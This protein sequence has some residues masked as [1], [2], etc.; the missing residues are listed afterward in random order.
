[1]VAC[2]SSLRATTILQL[3]TKIYLYF[4]VLLDYFQ[5]LTKFSEYDKNNDLILWNNRRITIE[6]NSVLWKQWFDQGVTFISDLMNSNGKFLTFE[7]FQNKF[8]IK[9]NYL[10]YFQLIAAIPPDLK[11]KA[12][13]STVPDLLGATSEYCQIEDRTIVFLKIITVCSSR[14][15]L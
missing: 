5:E 10:H 2:P 6:R 1:M 15:L 14:N 13:G 12:F 3:L 9:A 11:R 7:E 8:E 4:T